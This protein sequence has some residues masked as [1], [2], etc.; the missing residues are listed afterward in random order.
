MNLHGKMPPT[1]THKQQTTQPHPGFVLCT[2]VSWHLNILHIIYIEC[3]SISRPGGQHD[4]TAQIPHTRTFFE[5]QKQQLRCEFTQHGA[6]C[7]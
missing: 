7:F 1:P 6:L 4:T 3:G 2:F 5:R